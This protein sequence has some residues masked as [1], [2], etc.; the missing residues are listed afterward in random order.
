MVSN[1][2]RRVTDADEVWKNEPDAA[3][4]RSVRDRGPFG[5]RIGANLSGIGPV[6]RELFQEL[7]RGP[8]ADREFRVLL[9]MLGILQKRI[10]PLRRLVRG[11]R[12]DPLSLQ[13]RGV[14]S[15]DWTVSDPKLVVPDP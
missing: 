1:L 7:L 9:G 15:D 4:L 6:V 14:P 13:G 11:R 2:K 12:L 3:G 8:L 5:T 10:V